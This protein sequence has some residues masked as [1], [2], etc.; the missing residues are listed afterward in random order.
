MC[1]AN[2]LLLDDDRWKNLRCMFIGTGY[3][4]SMLYLREMLPGKDVS[5]EENQRIK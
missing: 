2:G 3:T 1:V 4:M 5:G